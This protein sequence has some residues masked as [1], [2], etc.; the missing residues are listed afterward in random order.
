MCTRLRIISGAAEYLGISGICAS[1]EPG[2]LCKTQV[3]S[4]L[5]LPLAEPRVAAALA[6]LNVLAQLSALL[7]AAGG[8]VTTA[9]AAVAAAGGVDSPLFVRQTVFSVALHPDAELVGDSTLALTPFYGLLLATFLPV[10]WAQL[11]LNVWALLTLG[12]FLEAR[13]GYVPFVA[14]ALLSGATGASLDLLWLSE[15]STMDYFAGFAGI[16]GLLGAL[17]GFLARNPAYGRPS[18]PQL[19]NAVALAVVS[20]ALSAADLG[21]APDAAAIASHALPAAGAAAGGAWL[22]F[23]MVGAL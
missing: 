15:S 12:A 16:A 14:V 13:L 11:A 1:N 21:D 5:D 4:A 2:L 20:A 9:G 6:A 10:G 23:A 22:A 3:G 19:A 7:Y 17:A 8:D 18:G